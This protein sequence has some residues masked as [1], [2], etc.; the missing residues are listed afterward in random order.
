M[1]GAAV[2]PQRKNSSQGKAS[3]CFSDGALGILLMLN[4]WEKQKS[5][6]LGW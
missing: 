1:Q 6:K 2:K 4:S 5:D 3:K